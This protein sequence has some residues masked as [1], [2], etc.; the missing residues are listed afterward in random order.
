MN[1]NI[2]NGVNPYLNSLLHPPGTDDQPSLWA[3]FHSSHINHIA[4][5]LNEQLPVHYTAYSEQ[6]LQVRGVDWG[7]EIIL[8]R[9]RPDVTVF[10][11]G[12]GGSPPIVARAAAHPT[13]EAA[14]AT[15][16]EPV[17]R[18][19]A[20]VIRALEADATLGRVVA[21]IEVLSPSNKPGGSDYSAYENKRI[22][23]LESGIPLI[24]IDYLHETPPVIHGIPVYPEAPGAYP[25]L[26]AVSDL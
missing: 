19:V 14:I 8:R 2:F 24:E 25:Y 22:E 17:K 5:F 4:D 18:P 21:R 16:I 20:V 12:M 10:Q 15:V 7:D 26:I 23:T 1:T 11:Q 9:P 6:S 13:W 3:A